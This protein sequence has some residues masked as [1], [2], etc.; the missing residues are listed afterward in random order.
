MPPNLLINCY[1]IIATPYPFLRVAREATLHKVWTPNNIESKEIAGSISNK[2]PRLRNNIV[3]SV[4]HMQG[5]A[6]IMVPSVD[7]QVKL[8]N[9]LRWMAKIEAAGMQIL[10]QYERHMDA[11]AKASM[12]LHN[13]ADFAK[14]NMM[15]SAWSEA[16]T[17]NPAVMTIF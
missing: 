10:P 4:S 2:K 11:V 15:R 3:Q 12:A 9:S 14:Y 13:V 8:D 1:R 5:Y 6:P 17:G 16:V 7:H